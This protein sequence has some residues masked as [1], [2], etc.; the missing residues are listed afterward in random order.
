MKTILITGA[1]SGFGKEMAIYL[2]ELGHNVIGTSRS[3][4]STGQDYVM[5]TLDVTSDDS[6]RLC[7]QEAMETF[8]HIDV[9]INNAGNGIGG[10]IEETPIEKVKA[11]F[12]SNFFEVVRMNQAVLPIMKKQ[13]RR[14]IINISSIGGAIGLPY[15]GFYAAS[16][17]AL[18]GYTGALRMELD[19]SPISI[20]NICLGD[21]NTGFTAARSNPQNVSADYLDHY[22]TIMAQ[23]EE[24]E[25]N[26][27]S[28]KLIAELV[29][30]IINKK[31]KHPVRYI[32]GK[33]TERIAVKL[34]GLLGSKTFEN[35]LLKSLN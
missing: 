11:Q 30:R 12:D 35:I 20:T 14:L 15:Q 4:S 32:V 26:G 34:K 28:P 29:E 21:F 16:K 19:H 9:L 3:C 33:P 18:E 5:R 13:G 27:S 25:K 2:T 8:G 17:F 1:S 23:Y 6:V 10:P 31:D 24:N 22:N 7:V